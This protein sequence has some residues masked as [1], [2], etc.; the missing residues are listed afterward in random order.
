MIAMGVV[1]G[2]DRYSKFI[3]F[4]LTVT[5]ARSKNLTPVRVAVVLVTID[6]RVVLASDPRLCFNSYDNTLGFL[7]T[8]H[9]QADGD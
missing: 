5:L 2:K 9:Q 7:W 6:V 1:I 8:L 4:H 3:R